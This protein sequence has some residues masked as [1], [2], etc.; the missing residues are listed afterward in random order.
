MSEEVWK[1]I[2]GYEG[3]YQVSNMGR[4]KSLSRIRYG[5]TPT[6]KARCYK[7]K[8]LSIHVDQVGYCQVQLWKNSVG[9]M[10]GLHRLVA[11]AFI[12]NPHNYP[13]INHKDEVKGN[14]V[15]SNLEWCDYTYN[16]NYGTARKRSSEKLSRAVICMDA[17]GRVIKRFNSQ[18]DAV[19]FL[20]VSSNAHISSC[21]H[22][23][24]KTAY[25]YKWAFESYDKKGGDA[26]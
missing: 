14:N 5:N 25:G 6:T 20:G 22:G 21:C 15:V 23:K 8:L 12:E 24:E 10:L 9:K 3:I 16:N 18:K 26:Q 11:Q 17:S 4:V 13:C 1:D 7:E 2:T 19:A